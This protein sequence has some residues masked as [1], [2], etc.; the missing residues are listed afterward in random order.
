MNEFRAYNS[1]WRMVLLFL[2]ALGCV[3]AGLWFVGAFGEPPE[4]NV[5]RRRGRVAQEFALY[6]GWASIIFFG[7]GTPI[8]AKKLFSREPHLVIDERGIHSPQWSDATIP[9]SEITEV[10]T[11]FEKTIVLHLAEPGRFPGKG[12]GRILSG[13]NK[14]L[15]GG[16]IAISL[17]GTDREVDDAMTAIASFQD[18]LS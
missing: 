12:L 5:A 6:G 3:A 18:K 15:T 11:W 4:F 14:A 17:V 10:T 13:A 16:N 7:L 2:G 9:W 1:R 8:I